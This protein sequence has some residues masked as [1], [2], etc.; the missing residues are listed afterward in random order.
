MTQTGWT[1]VDVYSVSSKSDS[2]SLYLLLSSCIQALQCWPWNSRFL[3]R[4]ETN[5][6]YRGQHSWAWI[7][8]THDIGVTIFNRRNT[9][10]SSI[11]LKN[12]PDPH[13]VHV[14]SQLTESLI[15]RYAHNPNTRIHWRTQQT[16]DAIIPSLLRQNDVTQSLWCNNDVIIA[17]CIRWVVTVTRTLHADTCTK[18]DN[19]LCQ[20]FIFVVTEF[21]SVYVQFLIYKYSYLC[22][23]KAVC[24]IH[25]TILLVD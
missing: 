19:N 17:S 18:Q 7:R 3:S 13:L 20:P 21:G 16:H 12:I 9:S 14:R 23:L 25:Q 11:S 22:Q 24:H 2:E 6:L 5:R 8:D 10:T 15:Q 4:H 1:P